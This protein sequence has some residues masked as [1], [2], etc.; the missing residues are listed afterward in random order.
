MKKK[1]KEV[2]EKIKNMDKE[3]ISNKQKMKE[4]YER[5]YSEK[6]TSIKQE[7]L[8]LKTEEKKLNTQLG[9]LTQNRSEEPRSAP[10]N[11]EADL[12]NFYSIYG[13]S[14][15]ALEAHLPSFREGT[16]RLIEI[17]NE[18][19]SLF[20]SKDIWKYKSFIFSLPDLDKINK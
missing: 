19:M 18:G 4:I 13:Q 14:M 3:F 16:R 7:I 2:E 10:P 20:N 12:L 5:A 1:K 9:S 8:R 11:I 15:K 6:Y 17:V